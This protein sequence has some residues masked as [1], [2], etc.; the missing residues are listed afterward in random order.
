M[1]NSRAV[2]GHPGEGP[3]SGTNA[4]VLQAGGLL[5][6]EKLLSFILKLLVSLCIDT[7][8]L[9]PAASYVVFAVCALL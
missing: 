8:S 1:P 6:G 7:P 4:G 9:H 3:E 5:S 2:G